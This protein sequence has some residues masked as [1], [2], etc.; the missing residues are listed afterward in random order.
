[1]SQ[2]QSDKEF[3]ISNYLFFQK[4]IKRLIIC[5]PGGSG[6][7]YYRYHLQKKGFKY[8]IPWTSRPIRLGEVQGVDYI[9][10]SPE[11]A[12]AA[13]VQESFYEYNFFA[14]WFYGTPKSEFH[15]SNLFIMTPSGIAKLHQ[16]DRAESF[17]LYLDIDLEVRRAR[18]QNRNDADSVKRR[19]KTDQEDFS[20]F[21][22]FDL[23]I[24]DPSYKIT[25]EI[26]SDPS[27]YK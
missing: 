16:E 27:Y 1:M 3:P 15:A 14:N 25:D 2:S 18:L 17:I 12:S 6:K 11:E 21:L 13:I 22:D 9:F 20:G 5:G 26:W 23:S 8:S 7:D 24:T 4:P 10:V 19:L